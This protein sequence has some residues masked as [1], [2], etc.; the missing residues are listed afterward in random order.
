MMYAMFSRAR[1]KKKKK[2]KKR[3]KRGGNSCLYTHCQAAGKLT[4]LKFGTERDIERVIERD[5]EQVIE[6]DIEQVIEQVSGIMLGKDLEDDGLSGARVRVDA[7]LLLTTETPHTKRRTAREVRGR[8]D[9]YQM[10]LLDCWRR[11]NNLL[12]LQMHRDMK[13]NGSRHHVQ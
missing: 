10:I 2:E 4:I 8:L 1:M 3:R 6:R 5:I 7:W 13:Q 9:I 12:I 11:H